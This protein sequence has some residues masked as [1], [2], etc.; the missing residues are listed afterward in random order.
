MTGYGRGARIV[1]GRD[2]T[3]ELK[4]VNHRFL[5]LAFRMP[6]S[7]AC[8]EDS[9]RQLMQSRLSRGH[10][11][12]FVTYRNLRDDS[13]SVAVDHALLNA[14]RAAM[15]EMSGLTGLEDNARL[16]DYARMP[17]VLRVDEA[18]ED[19][20]AL[21]ALA[22][23][24]MNDAIDELLAMRVKEGERMGA[25]I[26]ARLCNIEKLTVGVA[27][28]APLVVEEY[29]V[30]LTQRVTEIMEGQPVDLARITQEVAM[31]CDRVNID[32]EIARM[33]SHLK[34]M[35]DAMASGAAVGRKLD[36]I[37]Q[38]MNREANT[39]GSKASDIELVSHVVNLK[40]E[41]EKIREQVQN[42]E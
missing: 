38:E 30:R 18:E 5:D 17:D 1:D 41:I 29:R 13:K 12:V 27:A 11:D 6:R 42:I 3:I 15:Q 22:L 28:R 37:V 7:F 24:C 9:L 4:S 8:L 32:E 25:D 39:M 21:K 10:I 14:Y 31:Y 20:D 19:R 35:R 16:T 33:H 2:L 40:S 23:D 36:F 34:G 26:E